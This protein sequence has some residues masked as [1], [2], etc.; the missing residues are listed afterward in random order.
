MLGVIKRNFAHL[1]VDT[2]VLLYKSMVRS[3]IEY[4]HS[5]WA[6][7]RKMDSEEIE[8]VQRRATKLVKRI[9]G[10]KYSERLKCCGLPTLKYRR[11]RGDMI[12]TYK[13]LTGKYDNE[14]IPKLELCKSTVTRGNSFKL[15]THR[16][17]YDLR[18]Y[19]F[20]NRI[21]NTWNSLPDEIVTSITTN[22]FKNTLDR[23]WGEQELLYN[24]KADLTGAGNRSRIVI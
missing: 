7:Y 9:S 17:R 14:V 18:K 3:H 22:Q 23:F 13:I 11:I 24:Y 8:R 21:V 16:T 4:G 15:A 12:E 10:L 20:S 5:V 6:P 2:F 19:F 1:T